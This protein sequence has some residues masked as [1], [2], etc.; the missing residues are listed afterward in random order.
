MRRILPPENVVKFL[1]MVRDAGQ[2]LPPGEKTE[3]AVEHFRRRRQELIQFLEGAV[4]LG[5]PIWC[6]L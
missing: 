3:T 6:D 2:R 5:E 1:E 4:E